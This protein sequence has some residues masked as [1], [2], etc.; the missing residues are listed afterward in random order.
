[1]LPFLDF[2]SCAPFFYLI[3]LP[4]FSYSLSSEV[5]QFK[6][7]SILTIL[8]NKHHKFKDSGFFQSFQLQQF[9]SNCSRIVPQIETTKFFPNNFLF[10]FQE[11][12]IPIFLISGLKL[13]KNSIADV[14]LMKK[15]PFLILIGNSMKH[16]LLSYHTLD[17]AVS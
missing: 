7:Q 4:V 1:M 15:N 9:C 6:N 17:V 14:F 8:G 11:W 13:L 3:P 5:Q 12:Q 2:L 10:L 16:T